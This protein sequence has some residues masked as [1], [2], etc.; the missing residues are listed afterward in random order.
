MSY[1]TIGTHLEMLRDNVRTGAYRSAINEVIKPG[2]RVL[3]FGCG[4]G[5]LSIFAERA[6][7]SKV[8]ALD[9]TRMLTAAEH[10]FRKN[11][12]KNI[13]T[14]F[15]EGDTVELPGQVDVIVSE[16]M[17]HFLFAERML[18]PLI[19]LRDKF[20]RSGGLIIP[21]YCSLHVGLVV[22]PTLYEELSFLR[23]R[24]Y[25]IDLSPV[26]DWPFT[27]V[28]IRRVSAED[29]LP[30]TICLREFSLND[31][32]ETPGLLTGVIVPKRET[33]VYGMCGWFEAQLS[34]SIRLSTSP[35]AP[36]THWFQFYFPF[37]Y[38]LRVVADEPIEIEVEIVPQRGQNGYR[39]CALTANSIREGESLEE[40]PHRE[41][42]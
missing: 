23:T 31:V 25:D 26:E 42:T 29:L 27:D 32:R 8:Y 36:A 28:A 34:P 4:T 39:W 33:V 22:T 15:G 7:A 10:I 40:D 11:G 24:P 17:G 3:D 6:G 5:V 9:R 2:D 30:E 41:G 12:C 38:P 37:A 35:F 16:W 21:H 18:E 14:I 1:A 20:L 13:E 19:T